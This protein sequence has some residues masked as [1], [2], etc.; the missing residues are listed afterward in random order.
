[1]PYKAMNEKAVIVTAPS[2]AGKTTIVKHLLGIINLKLVFSISACTRPVRKGEVNGRDYH[3]ISVEQFKN[4]IDEGAFVEWEEVY[5]NSYYGT[6]KS[7]V[8]RIW[9]MNHHLLFD[10]DVMGGVN[11]KSKF[12]ENALAIFVM[13]PSMEV[14]KQRLEQRGTE[15]DEKIKNRI[16]K[17]SLELKFA[18]KFDVIVLNDDLQKTLEETE[19]LVTDFLKQSS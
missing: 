12:G 10:V 17:A 19:K 1:M 16:N 9:N 18:K 3:F 4:M 15:S 11:L 14:L 6:L 13:P 7:E 8:E 2:G 5:K